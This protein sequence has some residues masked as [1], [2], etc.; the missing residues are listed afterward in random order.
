MKIFQSI[1]NT[2]NIFI[3]IESIQK[4]MKLNVNKM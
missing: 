1:D 4:E 2:H 3:S